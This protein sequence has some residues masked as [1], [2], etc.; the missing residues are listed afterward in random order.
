MF[1]DK[2]F[3]CRW[4]K[5]K[6]RF[7]CRAVDPARLNLDPPASSQILLVLGVTRSAVEG[8]ASLGSLLKTLLLC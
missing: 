3:I 4:I 6:M 1:E 2:G 7:H 5:A 8:S